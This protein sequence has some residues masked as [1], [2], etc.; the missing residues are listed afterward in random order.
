MHRFVLVA[1]RDWFFVAERGPRSGF[2]CNER[3]ASLVHKKLFRPDDFEQFDG[4]FVIAMNQSRSSITHSAKFD[5]EEL[6]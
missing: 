2:E 1:Q 5:V 6:G 3:R 4:W